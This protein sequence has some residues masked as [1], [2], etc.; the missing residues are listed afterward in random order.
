MIINYGYKKLRKIMDHRMP[1]GGLSE[2]QGYTRQEL[3]FID[4]QFDC[5]QKGTFNDKTFG[6]FIGGILCGM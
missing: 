1:I 6:R 3:R 5:F 2:L 4:D